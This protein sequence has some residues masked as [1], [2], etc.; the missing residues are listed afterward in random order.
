MLDEGDEIIK[1]DNNGQLS[2]DEI[3]EHKELLTELIK[4]GASWKMGHYYV[5][6]EQDLDGEIETAFDHGFHLGRGE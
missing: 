4:E 2:T 1:G 3:Q 6:H 5:Y